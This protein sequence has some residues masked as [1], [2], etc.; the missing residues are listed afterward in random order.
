MFPF[1]FQVVR[2]D[3][4]QGIRKKRPEL[5]QQLEKVLFHQ[6]NEFSHTAATTQ[7]EIGLLGFDQ[8][9]HPSYSPDLAP[10]DFAVFPQ[11]S[12]E[13]RGIKFTEFCEFKRITLN[14]VRRLDEVWCR[15]V[16]NKWIQRHRKCIDWMV[17]TLKK[18]DCS[19]LL[20]Y[21][22]QSA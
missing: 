14:A 1:V 15:N 9:T 21:Q 8:I 10:M 7:L 17:C 19:F 6:D 12:A 4:I 18:S 3:L 13:L 2:R 11:V 20:R 22:L 16:F 5:S